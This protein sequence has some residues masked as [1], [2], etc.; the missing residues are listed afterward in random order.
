MTTK[1]A[2]EIYSSKKAGN[3][4]KQALIFLANEAAKKLG[5]YPATVYQ[6]LTALDLVEPKL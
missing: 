5:F 2:F 1:T 4:R 3:E 6:T